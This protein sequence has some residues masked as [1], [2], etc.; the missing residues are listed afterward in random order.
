MEL[1]YSN[2]KYDISKVPAGS[3]VIDFYPELSD[4]TEFAKKEEDELVRWII[5]LVDDGSPFF[6]T[7]RDFKE[8]GKAVFKH[9]NLN[10][11]SLKKYIDGDLDREKEIQEKFR[12]NINAKIY[13]Y[14]II[15]DKNTYTVWYSLWSSFQQTNA[16][17]QME[18]DPEDYQFEAKFERKQKITDKLLEIQGKLANYEKQ[19]YGDSKIKQIVVNTV[20][21]AIYW[22]EKLVKKTEY[23]TNE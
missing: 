19:V 10:N 1:D 12:I 15:L 20:A 5:L 23:I 18:I 22:P 13:K 17:A 6:K 9:L 7:Y 2:L 14:F 3:K 4:Y 16:L 8:R 11:S 21:K